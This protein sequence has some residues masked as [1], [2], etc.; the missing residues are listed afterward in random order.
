MWLWHVIAHVSLLSLTRGHSGIMFRA[1][2]AVNCWHKLV[3]IMCDRPRICSVSSVVVL[4]C[5]YAVG[6]RV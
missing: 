2:C 4:A 1:V 3:E 5:T 6:A